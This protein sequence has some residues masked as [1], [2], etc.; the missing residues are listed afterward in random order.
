MYYLLLLFMFASLRFNKLPINEHDDEYDNF[1][2]MSSI[3]TIFRSLL[4]C[5]CLVA[6]WRTTHTS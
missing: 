5:I 1:V 6:F 4:C 2:F 3:A